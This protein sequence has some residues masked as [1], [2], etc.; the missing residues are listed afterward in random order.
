MYIIICDVIILHV[1]LMEFAMCSAIILASYN[2]KVINLISTSH[3]TH[4]HYI[5]QIWGSLEREGRLWRK[6]SDLHDNTD[7]V[8]RSYLWIA[9]RGK[10]GGKLTLFLH[11]TKPSLVGLAPGIFLVLFSILHGLVMNGYLYNWTLQYCCFTLKA[12]SYF[13]F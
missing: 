8:G 3:H 1:E 12:S 13:P 4:C 2:T 7:P 9:A 11:L 5:S 6:G 10:L